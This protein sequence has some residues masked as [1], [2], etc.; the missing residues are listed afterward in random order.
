MAVD[1]LDAKL[2][3]NLRVADLNVASAWYERVFGTQPIYRGV[4]RTMDGAATSMVCFRLGGVKFWLLPRS[5][6][7]PAET[8]RI[9]LAFM[10]RQ[11]LA[12]LRRELEARGAQ[13][14]DTPSPGFP[15]DEHGVR[16]GQDAEFMYIVDP[17][18]HKLEFCHTYGAAGAA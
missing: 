6:D 18:G 12:P 14:D 13:F 5:K 9:G 3:I 10:T 17:D 2:D 7:E 4:D 16:T 15:I 1:P 8:Q 11:R